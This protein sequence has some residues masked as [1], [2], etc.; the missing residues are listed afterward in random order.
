MNFPDGLVPIG[1]VVASH[2]IYWPLL[3]L[4]LVRAPWARLRDGHAMHVLLGTTVGVMLV[5]TMKAGFAAGLNLHLL[6][7]TLVTLMFGWSFAAV[8]ISL[9]VLGIAINDGAG[10]QVFAI[11]ALL[12]GLLPVSVSYGLY[13]LV[14]RR[15]PNHLFVYI[16]LNAFFGAAI[17][18]AAVG[19]TST[20]V[21]GLAGAYTLEYLLDNYLRYYPLLMFPEAF[22]TGMLITVF[23]VYRPAWVSTFD[24]ERYLKNH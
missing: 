8:S 4:V 23:V 19:F 21:L 2:V 14:D 18:I 9:V 15:L 6:G 7:A 12:L 3:V 10:W 13:R 24:D 11:N 16:F 22:L 1:W 5:W 20:A 17:A